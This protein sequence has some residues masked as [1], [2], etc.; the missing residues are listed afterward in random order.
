MGNK[1]QKQNILDHLKSGYGITPLDA[2]EKFGCFRLAAVIHDLKKEGY[3]IKTT[4]VKMNN[5][6]FAVYGLKNH[7]SWN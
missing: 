1:T 7:S 2:L 5:K 3:E 4:M 6:K